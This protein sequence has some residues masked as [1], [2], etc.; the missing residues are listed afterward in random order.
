MATIS[1]C[2][3]VRNEEDHIRRC[4]E[5]AG[6]LV[7]EIVIVD[8]GSADGTKR[9]AGE[10]GAHLYD[11]E[12]TNDYAQARNFSLEKASCDW[13]LWLDADEELQIHDFP[14]LQS[15]L[16]NKQDDFL[17]VRMLHF[18]GQHPADERRS[19]V[20]SAFR[21]FRNRAGIRFMGKIHEQLTAGATATP[22]RIESNRFMRI[23][24]YGYMENEQKRKVSRNIS[25]LLENQGIEP[26][27]AWLDYH[28]AAEYYCSRDYIKAFQF[29]NTAIIRFLEKGVLPPPL[30]YKLKYDILIATG[31]FA[32][33]YP[34]IEKAIELY[35]D[36]V[37]L[38]FYKGRV[39]FAFKEYEKAAR[40]FSYC[41]IL[42]EANPEYLILSG[43]GSFF[44]LHYL[45]LCYQ[46]QQKYELAVGSYRQAIALYPDFKPARQRLEQ[47]LKNNQSLKTW[48]DPAFA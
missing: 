43:A 7:D 6:R 24:H 34:G 35:P 3:I 37:D 1:L 18:Y 13:I 12:W 20:C 14:A 38:Y 40:T 9:I 47:L 36:Y 19:H 17:A 26:D 42:G 10:F 39:Q 27:N 15:C 44:A 21:L 32:A 31:N 28:L 48:F 8:T 45:G 29:V 11:F 41:L 5:S 22:P 23:L 46:M 16:Q 33:A 30:A 25:L 4:L 2:M